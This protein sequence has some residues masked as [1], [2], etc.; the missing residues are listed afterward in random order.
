MNIRSGTLPVPLC[1]GFG[2]A[3]KI[4]NKNEN[5]NEKTKGL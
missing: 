2:E 1:V 5:R 4:A 3:A